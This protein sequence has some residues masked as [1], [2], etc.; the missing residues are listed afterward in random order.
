M[1]PTGKSI[2]VSVRACVRAVRLPSGNAVKFS[3]AAF[4][5]S[6]FGSPDVPFSLLPAAGFPFSFENP[7]ESK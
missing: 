2:S 1:R 4:P 7:I 3:G 6:L 5:F